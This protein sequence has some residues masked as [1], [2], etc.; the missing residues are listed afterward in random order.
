MPWMHLSR[1]KA[2]GRGGRAAARSALWLAIAVLLQVLVGIVTLVWSVPFGMALIHQAGAFIVLGLALYH[3][4]CLVAP[5]SV[6]VRQPA[7]A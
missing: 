5:V 7:A 1:Q 4:H 3:L 2:S 6:T